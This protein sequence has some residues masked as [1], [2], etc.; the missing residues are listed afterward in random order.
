MKKHG[1]F[2]KFACHSCTGSTLIFTALFNFSTCAAE[3]STVLTIFFL[4]RAALVAHGISQAR[5][6]IGA[7]AATLHHSHGNSRQRWI[8][9]P[10]RKARDW[11]PVLM[12]TS[13][14]CYCWAIMGTPYKNQLR[15]SHGYNL[16]LKIDALTGFLLPVLILFGLGH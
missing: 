13:R 10:L 7:I 16:S 9:N 8:L 6:W 2:H 12:D 3:V 1:T 15:F 14:V 5:G 11:T 4:F